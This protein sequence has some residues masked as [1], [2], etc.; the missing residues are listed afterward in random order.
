MN[1][2]LGKQMEYAICG[3]AQ[4]SAAE[5]LASTGPWVRAHIAHA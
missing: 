4:N 3:M 2:K 1:F 5:L